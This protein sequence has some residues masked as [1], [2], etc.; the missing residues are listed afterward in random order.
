MKKKK[1]KMN[2]LLGSCL[3]L[4]SIQERA[5]KRKLYLIFLTKST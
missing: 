1:K 3:C 4:I 5:N 2:S